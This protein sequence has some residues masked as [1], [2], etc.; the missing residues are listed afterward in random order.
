[1]I[2]ANL[3]WGL[4]SGAV[5]TVVITHPD[6]VIVGRGPAAGCGAHSHGRATV[7][8]WGSIA[9]RDHAKLCGMILILPAFQ[10]HASSAPGIP[11]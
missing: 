9:A 4:V 1:M 10:P 7:G 5:L 8:G 6:T 2:L 11:E 3:G